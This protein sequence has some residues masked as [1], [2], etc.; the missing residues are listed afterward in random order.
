MKKK[1]IKK[2]SAA[3]LTA[4]MVLSLFQGTKGTMTVQAAE[5]TAPASEYWTDVEGL[6]KFSLSSGDIK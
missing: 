5:N 1:W 2:G 6:K 3:L 4:A